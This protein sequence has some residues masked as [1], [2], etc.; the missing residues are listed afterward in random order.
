MVLFIPRVQFIA[1]TGSLLLI[2]MLLYLIR[3][4]RIKEEYSLLWLFFGFVF[5]LFSI[6]RDG[7]EYMARLA[8]IAYAPAML[9]L[10][11]TLAFFLIL[12]EFSVI[13]SRLSDR[14]K[15]LTQELGLLNLEL[16]KLKEKLLKIEQEKDKKREE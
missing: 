12:I 16:K 13:L 6:W 7:L 8:G 10:L 3:K 4:Q 1:I 2:L 15:V 9:F 14:N 11:F 5:L